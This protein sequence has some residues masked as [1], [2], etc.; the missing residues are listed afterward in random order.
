[1]AENLMELTLE[2]LGV[3]E[4]TLSQ[5]RLTMVLEML[6]S[7]PHLML[8][9]W[10]QLFSIDEDFADETLEQLWHTGDKRLREKIFHCR[11]LKLTEEKP[12]SDWMIETLA[13]FLAKLC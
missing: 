11:S 12:D 2:C 1:M 5:Q 13:E 9:D 7:M 4:E 10:R 6:I 3:R 8:S